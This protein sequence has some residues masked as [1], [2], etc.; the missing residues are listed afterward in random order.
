M[1]CMCSTMI[2]IRSRLTGFEADIHDITVRFITFKLWFIFVFGSRVNPNLVP[3]LN[4][5]PCSLDPP[6]THYEPWKA[7]GLTR[8][9]RGRYSR[10][11]GK[12]KRRARDSR[13][14]PVEG[15]ADGCDAR[16]LSA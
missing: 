8:A 15:G 11:H 12:S 3:C 14:P 2:M 9:V 13:A 6:R 4:L 1:I 16:A 10:H 7:V 5:V